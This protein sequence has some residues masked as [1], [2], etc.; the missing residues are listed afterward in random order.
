MSNT[1]ITPYT[2]PAAQAEANR[3]ALGVPDDVHFYVCAIPGQSRRYAVV[4]E[5]SYSR[6]AQSDAIGRTVYAQNGRGARM[7]KER[8]AS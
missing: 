6:L 8:M 7:G 3:L 2:L 1:N 5:N 4:H